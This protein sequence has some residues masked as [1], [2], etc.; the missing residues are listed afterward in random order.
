M[1][2]DIEERRPKRQKRDSSY[3]AK[4]F[5]K[6]KQL[7]NGLRSKYEVEEIE[8]V[9]ETVDEK[10]YTKQVLARQDDDWIVDDD[11][12]GYV[13]DGRDIFDDDLDKESIAVASTSK[14]KGVKRKK[15]VAENAGRG[16]L[17]FMISNMPTKKKEE[18][19]LE[20]DE[21]LA[22]L[23]Q[24]IDSTP[25]TTPLRPKAIPSNFSPLSV[26]QAEKKYMNSLTSSVKRPTINLTKPV[27]KTPVAKKDVAPVVEKEE[28]RSVL[29]DL[30]EFEAEAV[31]LA[32]ETQETAQTESVVQTSEVIPETQ[33]SEMQDIDGDCFTDDLDVSQL[34]EAEAKAERESDPWENIEIEMMKE[35][36][37]TSEFNEIENSVDLSNSD[38][39]LTDS[40]GK[41][42]FRF[43]WWD[44]FE[45][46]AKQPGVVFLFGKTYHDKTKSYLSCC[47]AVRN[48]E[49][50]LFF[51]PRTTE[52]NSDKPVTAQDVYTEINESVMKNLHVKNFKSRPITKK[53]AFD[54]SIPA[55]SDYVEVRYSAKDPP[56]SKTAE[57][58]TFSRVF[59]TESSYLEIFLLDRKIKGPCWLDVASPVPVTNPV[60]WCKLEIN[61][62]KVADV[63]IATDVKGRPPLVV[64]S[65]NMRRAVNPKTSSNEIVMLSCVTNTCYSVDKQ[66][67]AQAFQK[68]F[69]GKEVL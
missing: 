32:E 11:G 21:A 22:E 2:D 40:G 20:N 66:A 44:A 28:D 12:N 67:P 26:K 53:Y 36:A 64:T 68:H 10:E 56:I 65:I 51:L 59:G 62:N 55:E 63:V 47:L 14:G 48:I 17:Q 43:F 69:C 39:P 1:E 13:E 29:E 9:Y 52:K 24:E 33:L 35:W 41:K 27:A 46:V 6:F 42:V 50:R 60:S 7:K 8:N 18:E 34:D 57:G 25:T 15:K 38:L 58:R 37:A 30:D 5:E 4:A 61:C 54:T 3:K 45:D 16:N 23:L 49:R 31:T 19:K